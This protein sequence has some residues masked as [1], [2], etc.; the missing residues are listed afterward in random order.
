ML[1]AQLKGFFKKIFKINTGWGTMDRDGFN[2]EE[3]N[4]E[5]NK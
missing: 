4:E 5:Q 1:Y 2:E 3:E